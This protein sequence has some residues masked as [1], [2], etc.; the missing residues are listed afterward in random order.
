MI[1]RFRGE[2]MSESSRAEA[3]SQSEF[4]RQVEELFAAHGPAAFAAPLFG[5][6]KY[7]LFVD[8]ETVV[9]ESGESPRHKYGTFC[10]LEEALA[11][12]AL[13]AHVRQWLESGEAYAL[14]LSMNVCRYDC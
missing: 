3:L 6:P 4:N 10:E 11:G 7:T 8:G 14:Y 2:S 12:A 13:E 1:S 9:A 5:T